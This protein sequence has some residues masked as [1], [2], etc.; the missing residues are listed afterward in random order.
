MAALAILVIVINMYWFESDRCDPMVRP[1]ADRHYNRQSVGAKNFAPPGSCYVL[2]T[3]EYGA[4]WISSWPFAEYVKHAWAGAW[5]CTAF[6][7]ERR[8]HPLSSRPGRYLSSELIVQAVAAT[9]HQWGTPPPLGMITFVD[10]DETKPKEHPGKCFLEA[11]F[12]PAGGSKGGLVALKLDPADFPNPDAALAR[13]CGL[14]GD[15]VGQRWDA[16]LLSRLRE[17]SAH[18]DVTTVAP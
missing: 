2:T 3:V 17:S 18:V 13:Q 5:I 6:R 16:A 1:L 12:K 9:M 8:R 11:G 4:Y 15:R 14:F 10:V 7:N